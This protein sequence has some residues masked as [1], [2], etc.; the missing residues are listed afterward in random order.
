M[1]YL[2]FWLI[3]VRS[4]VSG[5]YIPLTWLWGAFLDLAKRLYSSLIVMVFRGSS[6]DGIGSI[7]KG[8]GPFIISTG[9][10]PV[11]TSKTPHKN[12]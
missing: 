11:A 3:H 4:F 2:A 7:L 6:W 9:G 8:K 1:L 5:V 12:T 10:G